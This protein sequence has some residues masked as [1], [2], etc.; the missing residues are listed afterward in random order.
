MN[1]P[2]VPH[3]PEK[4]IK[5]K[6]TAKEHHLIKCLRNVRFGKVIVHKADSILVRVETTESVLLNEKDGLAVE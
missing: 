2:F 4:E 6:I 1:K 3:Q 5:V